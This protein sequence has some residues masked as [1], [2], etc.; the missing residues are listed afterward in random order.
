MADGNVTR[1]RLANTKRCTRCGQDKESSA[2]ALRYRKVTRARSDGRRT[3]CRSCIA[4]QVRQKYIDRPEVAEK[5]RA[6]VKAWQKKR[7]TSERHREMWRAQK[8]RAR[9]RKGARPKGER[10]KDRLAEQNGRQAWVWWL[11]H[12]PDD[13]MRQYYEA[14]GKPWRNP[15]LTVSDAYRLRYAGDVVFYNR[16]YARLQAKKVRQRSVLGRRA[17]GMSA[18]QVRVVREAQSD[19]YMCGVYL[20]LHARTLDHIVPL[21]KGGLHDPDNVAVACLSCNSRKGARVFSKVLPGRIVGG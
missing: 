17:G 19:C 13:W 8:R 5:H 18:D 20:P 2:F 15:R 16:E 21:A 12:A 1:D 10:T 6:A 9:Y 7:F 4:E 14:M 3:I 11:K